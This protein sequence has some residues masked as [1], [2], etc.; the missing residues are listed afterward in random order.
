MQMQ[1]TEKDKKLISGLAV[2]VILVAGGYWGVLPMVKNI[3]AYNGQ[4]K[5]AQARQEMNEIKIAQ[6]SLLE[7]DN[8]KVEELLPSKR[9]REFR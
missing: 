2:F 7:T 8:E 1:M 3:I 9:T 5:D 6:V 4:I